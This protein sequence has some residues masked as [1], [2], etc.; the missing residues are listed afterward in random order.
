MLQKVKNV[1]K[2][3]LKAFFRKFGEIKT[4]RIIY[5]HESNVSRGFGFVVFKSK[6]SAEQVIVKKEEHFLHGKWI[7]C[8]SAILRQE[9]EQDPLLAAVIF[10]Y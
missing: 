2:D 6:A 9:I 7:D 4:C 5:R 8:K 1:Y 10:Y 3:E